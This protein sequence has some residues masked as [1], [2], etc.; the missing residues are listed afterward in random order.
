MRNSKTLWKI[1]TQHLPLNVF[2]SDIL[3]DKKK[4]KR[5]ILL[6]QQPVHRRNLNASFLCNCA[7]RAFCGTSNCF[8][9]AV[10]VARKAS[11]RK[12]HRTGFSG[13]ILFRFL[14]LVDCCTCDCGNHDLLHVQFQ[15]IVTCNTHKCI[16]SSIKRK[17]IATP[18]NDV[19]VCQIDCARLRTK[20]F[21]DAMIHVHRASCCDRSSTNLAF[22]SSY[23][24][25]LHPEPFT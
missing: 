20:Q 23:A 19:M 22:D 8:Q 18:T 13:F 24:P 25:P 5:R 1:S 17:E 3:A 7:L 9:N 6:S 4:A 2:S 15:G 10:Q 11:Q 21:H 12:S 16:R 14:T